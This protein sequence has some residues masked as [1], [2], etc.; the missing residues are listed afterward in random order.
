M[1]IISAEGW[2]RLFRIPDWGWLIIGCII[3][4]IYTWG[5]KIDWI[6]FRILKRSVIRCVSWIFCSRYITWEIQLYCRMLGKEDRRLQF[7][8]GFMICRMGWLRKLIMLGNRRRLRI[9]NMTILWILF[10]MK[11]SF[12]KVTRN[13][14][15]TRFF[16]VLF[17]FNVW[18]LIFRKI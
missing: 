6:E 13:Y 18:F 9:R 5:I 17:F 16:V 4:G 7:M 15:R 14:E 11:L 1:D 10:W 8:L 12:V 2:R 3:Y